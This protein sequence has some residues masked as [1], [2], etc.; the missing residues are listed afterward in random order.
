VLQTLLDSLTTA[1][2]AELHKTW[3]IKPQV[4]TNLKAGKHL[5]TQ[6][7]VVALAQVTGVDRHDLQDAVAVLREKDPGKRAQLVRA[8]GTLARGVVA[9]L[10][11]LV[12]VGSVSSGQ[13]A[14]AVTAAFLALGCATM[15]IM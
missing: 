8:M 4:V 11:V 10:I 1:Q 15:Y 5:P 13:E 2:R 14:A 6:D 12:V 7:Q 3:G 9:S